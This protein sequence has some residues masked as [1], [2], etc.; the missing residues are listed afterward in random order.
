MR[1]HL[2][3]VPAARAFTGPDAWWSRSLEVSALVL[4]TVVLFSWLHRSSYQAPMLDPLLAVPPALA[5]IGAA[6][7]RRPLAYGGLSPGAATIAAPQRD[8]YAPSLPGTI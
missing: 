6:S 7:V 8:E 3:G 5:G 4:L 2:S 1:Q